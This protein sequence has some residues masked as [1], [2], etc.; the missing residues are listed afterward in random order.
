MLAANLLARQAAA[1]AGYTTL[2]ELADITTTAAAA[3]DLGDFAPSTTKAAAGTQPRHR[4]SSSAAAA[5]STLPLDLD[6]RQL[7]ADA[8]AVQVCLQQLAATRRW[9]S[10]KE[11]GLRVQYRHEKGET[12]A[13]RL[14]TGHLALVCCAPRLSF[15]CNPPLQSRPST[16]FL[17][18]CQAQH[19][20]HPFL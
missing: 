2:L 6:L 15:A 19:P 16:V 4:S 12:K 18:V 20:Q 14:I 5:T 8:A 10:T 9:A 3:D 7:E 17:T 11:G 1:A 13:R